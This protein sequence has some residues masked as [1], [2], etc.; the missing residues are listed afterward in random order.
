[1]KTETWRKKLSK[2]AIMRE[3][4]VKGNDRTEKMNG[5]INKNSYNMEPTATVK[6]RNKKNGYKFQRKT[7]DGRKTKKHGKVGKKE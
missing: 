3:K 4:R 2:E 7:K 5:E 6:H 1:M